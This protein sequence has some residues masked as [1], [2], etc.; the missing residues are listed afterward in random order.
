[1]AP[2]GANTELHDTANALSSVPPHASPLA[3]CRVKPSIVALVWIGNSVA[4]LAIPAC[5]AA[6]AVM[7]FIVEPG[8]C[9]A[10]KAM[11][12]AASSAPVRGFIT[13]IPAYWPPSEATAARSSA[14]SIV[15]LTGLAWR[16]AAVASVRR[17]ASSVPP[18]RPT[19]R[20]WKIRSRPSSPILAP[21]G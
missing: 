20:L 5:S 4:S 16:G 12:A 19:S 6:V 3:F 14:G 9:T 13:A 15:V 7:I 18:S 1:M 17:P 8:G 2:S 21:G 10:E 11:P